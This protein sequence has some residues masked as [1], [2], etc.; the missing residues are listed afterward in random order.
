MANSS[1]S[2]KDIER[3]IRKRGFLGGQY[4]EWHMQRTDEFI[5]HSENIR[6]VLDLIKGVK[7][8]RIAWL[9]NNLSPGLAS[10]PERRGFYKLESDED[11]MKCA[12]E[13]IINRISPHIENVRPGIKLGPG[14]FDLVDVVDSQIALIYLEVRRQLIAK[15]T[16]ECDYCGAI[17]PGTRKFCPPALSTEKESSCALKKRQERYRG[18]TNTAQS[19]SLCHFC[20]AARHLRPQG[21]L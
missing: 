11:L 7:N 6:K 3:F 1:G 9:R 17:I 19:L 8:N 10:P 4:S 5:Y 13:E 15:K 21:G 12:M 18:N 20:A 14:G 16:S 2:I